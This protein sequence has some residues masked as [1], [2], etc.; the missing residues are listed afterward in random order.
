[1]S[2][3]VAILPTRL[4][5]VVSAQQR[6]LASNPWEALPQRSREAA[7]LLKLLIT[8]VLQHMEQGVRLHAASALVASSLNAG[9][10]PAAY[11]AA[12]QS[13]GGSVS[14]GSLARWVG[15]FQAGGLLALAPAGKGRVRKSYGWESRAMALYLQ[16]SRP[17]YATVAYWLQ[18]E[19][20]ATALEHNVRRYL[21]SLPS[22]MAETSPKRLGAHYY[23]QNVR[24]YHRRDVT[25]LHVGERYESDGHCCDVYCGHPATGTHFRP[26]LTTLI[27][28]RSRYLVAFWLGEHESSIQTLYT[29]ARGIRVHNHVPTM[30]HTDP[31]SGFNN[32]ML[33][34][35]VHGYYE[36]LA[37]THEMTLPGNARGKGLQEGWFRWFEERLGKSFDTFCGHCRTDDALTRLRQRIAKGELNL[38]TFAQFYDAVAQYIHAY[39]HHPQEALGGKSPADL[40]ATLTPNPP[41]LD[42][43]L[44]L[45]PQ[46]ERTVRHWEVRLFNRVY[47]HASLQAYEGRKVR[48]EYDIHDA[49]VVLLRDAKGRAIA[50]APLVHATAAVQANVLEDRR[51]KSLAGAIGRLQ[52]RADELESRTHVPMSAAALLEAMDGPSTA[53]AVPSHAPDSALDASAWQTPAPVAPAPKPV[54][55]A[56]LADVAT[57]MAQEARQIPPTAAERF[58]YWQQL[59]AS[60]APLGP[61]DAAWFASYQQGSEWRGRMMVL[62]HEQYPQ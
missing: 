24:P 41:H 23:Q 39:N 40:W 57:A 10:M 47:R 36:R 51:A 43:A 61:E 12:V 55:A 29:L 59:Q 32:K 8:P 5:P 56:A 25:V 28:V 30:L 26:E 38:P 62:E 46:V 54:S 18:Q 44:L 1:M 11:Q 60:S 48:V 15:K 53:T 42:A 17:A 21:K 45:R 9:L 20:Y 50:E 35:K 31:G 33:G 6:A 13:Y 16:P 37:I 49:Q 3:N 22:H 7:Q 58:A 2:G 4:A 34:D 27:D 19:G 52:D 14:A